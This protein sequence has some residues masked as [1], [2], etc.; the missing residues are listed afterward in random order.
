MPAEGATL[1][2]ADD[3]GTDGGQRSGEVCVPTQMPKV[4]RSEI[5]SLRQKDRNGN[6][7]PRSGVNCGFL[8]RQRERFLSPAVFSAEKRKAGIMHERI[9]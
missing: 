3:A 2:G 4:Q 5:E 6:R 1:S 8:I 7:F 9:S